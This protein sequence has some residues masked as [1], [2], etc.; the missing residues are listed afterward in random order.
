M[1]NLSSHLSIKPVGIGIPTSFLDIV[2]D[3]TQNEI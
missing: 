1:D 2:E 3:C